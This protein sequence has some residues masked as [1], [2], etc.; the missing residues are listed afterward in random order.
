MMSRLETVTEKLM[1]I[2]LV[3]QPDFERELDTG[4]LGQ[5]RQRLAVRATILPLTKDESAEYVRFRLRR[6]GT[7]P[8][9]VFTRPALREIVRWSKGIPR[10]LNVLCDNALIAGFG[11]Q[12]K[13]VTKKIVKE[14]IRDFEGEKG[15]SL[16]R[17]QLARG[18]ALALL[19]LFLLGITWLLPLKRMLLGQT[20][21]SVSREQ[22][23]EAEAIRAVRPD[24][25]EPVMDRQERQVSPS[26][27]PAAPP[28]APEA[29]VAR[30]T[31]TS[32]DTLPQLVRDAYGFAGQH[33]AAEDPPRNGQAE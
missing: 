21:V 13:P 2:V 29:A 6:A 23:G 11:R 10:A 9:S 16:F 25:Y 33:D 7:D 24:Q 12:R 27:E 28:F 5:L 18:A 31:V 32:D 1:Q 17:R 26:R 14:T 8:A 4:R 20:A 30:N 19:L 22:A 3:G 15:P